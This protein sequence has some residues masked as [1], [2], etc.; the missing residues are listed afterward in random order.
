MFVFRYK[1]PMKKDCFTL[2]REVFIRNGNKL[3]KIYAYFYEE[4]KRCFTVLRML[5]TEEAVRVWRKGV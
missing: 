5:I 4:N 1:L 3:V 2:F